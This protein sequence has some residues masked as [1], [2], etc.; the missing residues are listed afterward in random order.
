MKIYDIITEGKQVLGEFSLMDSDIRKILEKK[1]YQALGAG[2][3][4]EAWLAPDGQTVLKIFGT[5]EN[6]K[7]LSADQKMFVKWAKFCQQ[8]S[9]NPF[10]PKY[11][12]WETFKHKG[13]LYLQ[14][15]TELLKPSGVL[16][17]AI[18]KLGMALDSNVVDYFNIATHPK[19]A[20]NYKIVSR[21]VGEQNVPLLL[22]TLLEL[23]HKTKIKTKY[24]WDL[25]GHNIMLRPNG[26]PVLNDPYTLGQNPSFF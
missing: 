10:L 8:N 7:N 22:N 23:I 13:E 12:G 18:A 5:Q 26:Q 21:H 3:D 25:G 17:E 4:Q 11:S 16:G 15:R 2:V 14:I 6:T 9:D 20:E 19:T 1:G 24:N